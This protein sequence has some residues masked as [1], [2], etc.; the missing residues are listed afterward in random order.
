MIRYRPLITQTLLLSVCLHAQIAKP[1]VAPIRTVTDEYF[2][3]KVDDPYRYLD[4]QKDPQVTT[5]MKAQA[6][7]TRAV[8]D[9][10]PGRAKLAAEIERYI[11]AEEFSITDVQIAGNSLFYRKRKRDE[12]LAP[13]YV[14]PVAGGDE[15]LLLNPNKLGTADHHVSLDGPIT[16]G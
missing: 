16:S 2:G 5:W 8:L 13:L 6:D 10:M 4:D 11:N 15:R 7:Y 9:S 3:Q 14:R 1:P 12:D